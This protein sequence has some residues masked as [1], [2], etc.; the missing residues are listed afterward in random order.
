MKTNPASTRHTLNV[1][2]VVL[3]D[4]SDSHRVRENRSPRLRFETAV[5]LRDAHAV[6]EDQL[7]RPPED[8][9]QKAD[10]GARHGGPT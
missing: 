2:G 4:G 6:E 5:I 1:A 8:E 10:D 7:L 3:S 9:G